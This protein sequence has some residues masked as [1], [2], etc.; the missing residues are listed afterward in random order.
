MGMEN[1]KIGKKIKGNK[2]NGKGEWE[3]RKK[4]KTHQSTQNRRIGRK[5][6]REQLKDGNE[7]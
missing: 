7:N 6:E 3:N 4:D 1:G 5:D 2:E